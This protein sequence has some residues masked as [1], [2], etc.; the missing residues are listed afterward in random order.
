[1][2]TEIKELVEFLSD[3]RVEICRQAVDIVLGL[4][5]SDPGL[6]RLIPELE[7]LLVSLGKLLGHKDEGIS[8]AALSTLVNLA[9]DLDTASQ[10]AAVVPRLME[11]VKAKGYAHKGLCFSAL[12]NITRDVEGAR[13]LLQSGDEALQG[14]PLAYLVHY[15]VGGAATGAAPRD[16]GE[17][18]GSEHAGHVLVNVTRLKGGRALMLDPSRG[19]LLKLLPLLGRDVT[20]DS[21]QRLTVATVIRNCCFESGSSDE[22]I[23]PVL[24]AAVAALLSALSMPAVP[25]LCTPGAAGIREAD[26][27]S[28]VAPQEDIVVAEAVL[29]LA[30]GTMGHALLNEAGALGVLR[31]YLEAA[32]DVGSSLGGRQ[33]EESRVLKPLRQAIQ[34]KCARG[35]G[36]VRKQYVLVFCVSLER[37]R[38][39]LHCVMRRLWFNRSAIVCKCVDVLTFCL[40]ADSWKHRRLYHMTLPRMAMQG[41]MVKNL[42]LNCI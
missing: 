9:G 35:I 16:P 34:M 8:R 39:K 12:A 37:C 14:L 31:K 30:A 24:Q 1:M 15:C 38:C 3:P 11:L 29:L 27:G 17:A 23:R 5:G 4:T 32:T 7:Q 40:C 22:A 21:S 2:S 26:G 13:A 6:A 19:L 10:M 20:A 18:L 41:R 42:W 25:Q 36:W 28:Q 33:A